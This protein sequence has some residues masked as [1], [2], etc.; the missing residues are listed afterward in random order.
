[1][2][3]RANELQVSKQDTSLEDVVHSINSFRSSSLSSSL[4]KALGYFDPFQAYCLLSHSWT[5]KKMASQWIS[6]WLY[7]HTYIYISILSGLYTS[8]RVSTSCIAELAASFSALPRNSFKE[9][10]KVGRLTS[11]RPASA[12]FSADKL[13]FIRA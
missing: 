13:T 8:G 9:M 11:G 3:G 6:F 10:N 2:P 4:K 12:S 1:M 7:I 5:R